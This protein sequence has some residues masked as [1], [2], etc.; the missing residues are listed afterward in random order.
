M[1]VY[2]LQ[3]NFHE[4]LKKA[5][6]LLK[7]DGVCIAPTDTQYGLIAH[8]LSQK[9]VERIFLMKNRQS[10]MRLPLIC[11]SINQVQKYMNLSSTAARLAD[12]FW[13]GPLT[14]V[15]ENKNSAT[16]RLSMP[17]NTIAVRIPDHEFCREVALQLDAPITAT[18]VNLSG[19]PPANEIK[20]MDS[21]LLSR[22]DAGFDDGACKD[23]QPSTIVKVESK[24]RIKVLRDGLIPKQDITL[25]T[26]VIVL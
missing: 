3:K 14:I 8:A 15:L 26:G 25:K 20:E 18:S 22:V 16:K 6:A 23:E 9:A 4:N 24:N 10:A 12:I 13:P 7:N 2:S 5:V 17:D 11:G 19:Q 21:A 1:I